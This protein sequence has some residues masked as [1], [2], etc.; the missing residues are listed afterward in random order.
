MQTV[1]FGGFLGPHADAVIRA[2]LAADARRRFHEHRARERAEALAARVRDGLIA[3]TLP[4]AA[5]LA[6]LDGPPPPAPAGLLRRL[7][8]ALR[9][10]ARACIATSTTKEAVHA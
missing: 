9:R 5:V 4:P 7:L 10:I 8:A 2:E 1:S 6:L 3:G